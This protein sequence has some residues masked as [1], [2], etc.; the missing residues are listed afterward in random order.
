M[1]LNETAPIGQIPG[2]GAGPGGIH[3][4]AGGPGSRLL[5]GLLLAAGS[6]LPGYAAVWLGAGLTARR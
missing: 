6:A 2:S 4:A 5:A 1:K 3:T